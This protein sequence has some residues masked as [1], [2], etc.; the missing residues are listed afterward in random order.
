MR[1]TLSSVACACEWA[2]T[3]VP[4]EQSSTAHVSNPIHALILN[5]C[6]NNITRKVEFFGSPV[7]TAARLTTLAQGG[8][9]LLSKEVY[10]K[11]HQKNSVTK[12]GTLVKLGKFHAGASEG[13]ES[14]LIYEYKPNTLSG[15]KFGRCH[16]ACL[17]KQILTDVLL[18]QHTSPQAGNFSDNE[19]MFSDEEDSIAELDDNPKHKY[20]QDISCARLS[21]SFLEKTRS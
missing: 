6:S 13:N 9:I 19:D 10:D 5:E 4:H 2:W 11:V 12:K 17:P 21:Q 8:Q 15:R 20:A 16:F 18:A 7:T 14:N 3:S 1:T